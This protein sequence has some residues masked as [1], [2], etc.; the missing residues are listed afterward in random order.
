MIVKKVYSNNVVL[1]TDNHSDKEHI[2]TG[3]GIGFNKKTGEKIDINKI[4]KKF[5]IV[6]DSFKSKIN[7]L[8]DEIPEE[9]FNVTSA[10]IEY[11][12]NELKT[13]L[14]E[15]IYISL[16][17]HIAFS[18]KR[19][20]ENMQVKNELLAEI[21]RIHKQEY[22]IG[23]WSLELINQKFG[24]KLGNDEAG[25]IAMHIVNANYREKTQ[26]S[27]LMMKIV[28]EILD[29]IK[30]FYSTEFIVEDIN[31]DRLLTHLKFFA[32]RLI[33]KTENLHSKNESILEIVKNQHKKAYDCVS[34][35]KTYIEANYSY[36]VSEEEV[37]YLVLHINRVMEVI[38]FKN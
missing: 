29:I 9:I 8:A 30:N 35:I 25:F 14:D 2:L 5:T 21:R 31:Y 3:C 13:N 11:S 16:I 36:K 12:E 17:D 15:Y 27:Y 6:D 26:E 28:D 1:V 4:E 7:K 33:D 38:D 18:L 10:I 19:E 32:K 20:K 37:L 22:N 23:K 34:T 24:T